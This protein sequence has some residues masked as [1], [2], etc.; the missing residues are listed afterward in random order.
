VKWINLA[1][2][3]EKWLAVVNVVMNIRAPH[4]PG[5]LLFQKLQAVASETKV[6]ISSRSFEAS[7]ELSNTVVFDNS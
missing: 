2:G 6:L 5:D 7:H 3:R 1:K 4:G